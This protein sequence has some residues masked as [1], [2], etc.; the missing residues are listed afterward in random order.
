MA[1]VRLGGRTGVVLVTCACLSL[2]VHPIPVQADDGPGER[3]TPFVRLFS[4]IGITGSSDLRIRQ[5]ALGTDLTFERVSWAHKSLSTR[6]TRDSIPYLGVRA[7]MFLRAPRWL[8]VSLE[9]L[10]FKILAEEAESVRISGVDEGRLVDTVS[11]MARFVQ[12]YRVSNGANMILG[13]VTAH[14]YLVRNPR[15]PAGRADL[16]VGLGAGVTIPYTSS[17]IDGQRQAQYD[18]GG[19]A[20]QVLGGLSWHMSRHWD[21]SLEYKFTRTTVDGAVAQGDSRSRL[22]TNH[23]TGGLGY[24]F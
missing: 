23:L 6:W 12:I 17:L 24:H 18:L 9:V 4:G 2:V 16:Y 3:R 13:T 7:G 21:I 15:F 22:R 10:H 8:G 14:R 20:T 11:P 19:L 1:D 5:P